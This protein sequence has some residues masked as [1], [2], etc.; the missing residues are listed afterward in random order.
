MSKISAASIFLL[1]FIIHAYEMIAKHKVFASL[2]FDNSR[3]YWLKIRASD[4]HKSALPDV[5][6]NVVTKRGYLECQTLNLVKLNLRITD[7]SNEVVVRSDTVI[8]GLVNG[9][10]EDAPQLF[11]ICESVGLADML[12]SFAELTTTRDYVRPEITGTLALSCARHPILEKVCAG[13][14]RKSQ[15]H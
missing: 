15:L 9:L 13:T 3:K 4:I 11:K 1:L 5:F 14:T 2:K 7:T 8:Q 12:A 10:Q 6:I